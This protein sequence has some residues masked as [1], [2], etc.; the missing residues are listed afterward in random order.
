MGARVG[1]FKFPRKIPPPPP[2]NFESDDPKYSY[3]Y[4]LLQNTILPAFLLRLSHK[5]ANNLKVKTYF[6]LSRVS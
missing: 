6:F 3:K 4:H 5:V 1:G 2:V